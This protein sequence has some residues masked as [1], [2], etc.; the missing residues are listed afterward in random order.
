MTYFLLRSSPPNYDGVV[1]YGLVTHCREILPFPINLPCLD[2]RFHDYASGLCYACS[3]LLKFSPFFYSQCYNMCQQYRKW[4]P[5]AGT[6]EV[7]GAKQHGSASAVQ[8]TG[9]TETPQV[10]GASEVQ[11]NPFSKMAVC[12]WLA[13]TVCMPR[14][15]VW[16]DDAVGIVVLELALGNGWWEDVHWVSDQGEKDYHCFHGGRQRHTGSLT[17]RPLFMPSVDLLGSMT[18]V[19]VECC[20][21]PGSSAWLCSPPP[22]IPVVGMRS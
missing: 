9:R 11:G 1:F 3:P 5:F 2:K 20:R 17:V 21:P 15:P 13:S 4:L 10:R 18:D 22:G 16:V 14:R 19:P 12:I 6:G 8:K 7:L